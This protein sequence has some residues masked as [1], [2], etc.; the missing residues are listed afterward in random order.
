M[1]KAV[2][3]SGLESES[4]RFG[5]I[6]EAGALPSAMPESAGANGLTTE[7]D[8]AAPIRKTDRRWVVAAL[9]L[10]MILSSME[11]TV[12]STAMP[13]II[14]NLQGLEHYSWVASLYLLACTVTMP[15]YGR[16]AD[17]LGRKRVILGATLIFTSGSVLAAMSHSMVQLILFRGVQGLGAGGIMP[18]VL[19]ILG[20]LF[21]LKERARMQGLF[22]AV[23]GISSLAGPALGA[24]LVQTLGWRW[25]FLVNL[26]FGLLGLI[27]LALTYHDHQKPHS[28]DLNLFGITLLSIASITLLSVV[29]GGLATV[30]N[31]V[32]IGVTVVATAVFIW[33]E[34]RTANPIL[35]PSLV[36]RQEVG[37][38]F[39]AMLFFGCAFLAL[40]TYVPLYVQGARGGG[41]G[42]A[43]GVVTPVMLTWATCHI[44]IAPLMIR[45]GFRKV[46]L[47]GCIAILVGFSGL[48]CGA[49]YDWP[50][51]ALT[52]VLAVTGF[53]FGASSMAYLLGA[54]DAVDYHQ[55]GIVTST[56]SF[57]RTIGGSMGVGL[58]GVMFNHLSVNK[59]EALASRGVSPEQA[60]DPK[61]QAALPPDTLAFIQQTIGNG[62]KWVFV[63]MLAVGVLQL[64]ASLLM[65]RKK[66]DHAISQSELLEAAH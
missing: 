49:F 40:D 41:A 31:L 1:A 11:M 26:P 34:R 12:T 3:D 36:L 60:M 20:D 32:L 9:M 65:R 16:L 25:V 19:T 66:P 37:P 43:A 35:P 22:S 27:V 64:V 55:R 52:V 17:V 54:Q 4:G 42:A 30:T 39:L 51:W 7:P 47:M 57:C 56:V 58:L 10:V 28:R 62:L 61:S 5:A 29:S 14:S 2:V 44:F 48:V 13:T 46:A 15:L 33:H 21:T 23:W 63:A 50:R 53:G 24:F 59:L 18:V 38:N 8:H 6:G 45:W